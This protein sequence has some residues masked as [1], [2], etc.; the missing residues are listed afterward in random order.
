MKSNIKAVILDW[1]GTTVDFGSNAPV[2]AFIRAFAAFGITPTM[3]ETRAPMGQQKRAHIESMLS[4]SRLS[5][6]WQEQHGRP[7][8]QEDIDR[9]YA[10]FEPLLLASLSDFAA[11]L[12]DVIRTVENLR[13]S[14]IKIGSTTGYTASM[15]RVVAPAAKELGYAPDCLVCPD[16]TGSGRPDPFMLW[17]NLEKLQIASIDAALKVGDTAADIA[18]GKNAGCLTVGVIKGSN[19]LGLSESE[20]GALST[21]EI[22][23]HYETAKKKYQAAGADYIIDDL[24]AL[25][26][27]VERINRER[28]N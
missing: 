2:A 4:G 17:R 18:E 24:S 3:E 25:P 23:A 12:P 21:V 26:A 28:G 20:F 6:L 9:I 5:A 15:M 14:G 13:E 7:H 11:P 1:A 16:E 27:L 10:E 19:M 8:T 22:A